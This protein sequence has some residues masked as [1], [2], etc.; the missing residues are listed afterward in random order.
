M[1]KEQLQ[2]VRDDIAFMRALAEEGS[3]VPMLGGGISAA[4][5]LIFGAASVI[6][7]LMQSDIL[8]VNG[9]FYMVNWVGAGVVFGVICSLLIKRSR[10]QAGANSSV[11]KATGSAWSA[12]GFAIFTTFLGMCAIGWVTKSDDVFYIFPVM[13]LALYGSAWSVAA[14]MSGKGWIR[15]VALASFAGAVLMG[16]LTNHPMQMLAYAA[17]LLLL[18]FVPGVILMRQEPSDTV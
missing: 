10:S 6:H 12:V 17:A 1:T 15:I 8:R 11:N 2:S 16:L 13:I 9:W 5:G 4:A 14:D 3:Q 18:A 7:W